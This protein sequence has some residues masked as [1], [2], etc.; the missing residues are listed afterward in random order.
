MNGPQQEA[1]VNQIAKHHVQRMLGLVLE[2]SR[3]IRD[4]HSQ[5][6]I[7][8]VGAMYDVQSGDVEFFDDAA[9]AL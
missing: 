5:G 2:R 3:A 8:V 9:P 4:L 7:K 1:L 6:R